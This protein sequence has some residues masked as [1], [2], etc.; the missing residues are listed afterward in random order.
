[1]YVVRE[2]REEGR[3]YACERKGIN[4]RK[5]ERGRAGEGGQP[6]RLVGRGGGVGWKVAT[7]VD[8]RLARR[9]LLAPAAASVASVAS[10]AAASFVV[11]ESVA[12]E[13]VAAE[14]DAVDVAEGAVAVAPLDATDVPPQ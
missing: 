13:S 3:N 7:G 5:G 4:D 8:L 2:E 11:D 14:D 10:V 12:D 6:Y 9:S 1:M